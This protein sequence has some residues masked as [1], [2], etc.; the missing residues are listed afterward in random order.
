[1]RILIAVGASIILLAT[2]AVAQQKQSEPKT[3]SD[4][5]WVCKSQSRPVSDCQTEREWCLKTGT[6]A[7]PKTKAVSM[8]LLKR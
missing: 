4:A 5:F 8:G 7:D 6:F 2:I 1:M 3:C